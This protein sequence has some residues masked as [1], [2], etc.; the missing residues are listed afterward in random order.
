MEGMSGSWEGWMGRGGTHVCIQLRRQRTYTTSCGGP[1]AP[2]VCTCDSSTLVG[3]EEGSFHAV[4]AFVRMMKVQEYCTPQGD[5][6]IGIV[7][8]GGPA[9]AVMSR[10]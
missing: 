7:R 8:V 9:P 6:T 5:H 3:A 4:P 10:V 2:L 1:Q